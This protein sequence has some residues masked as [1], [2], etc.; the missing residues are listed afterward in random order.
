MADS[1]TREIRHHWEEIAEQELGETPE[2]RTKCLAELRHLLSEDTLLRCPEDD[3]F[4]LK[5]LR[6]R[7]YHVEPTAKA[8]RAYFRA[9]TD[10][11]ELFRGLRPDSFDFDLLVRKHRLLMVLQER[12]SL[13]RAIGWLKIGAWDTSICSMVDLIRAAI[14]LTESAMLDEESQVNGAILVVD[15]TGFHLGHFRHLVPL[16]RR[17]VHLVQ[18][19]FPV[20]I[21]G[22]YTINFPSIAEVFLALL[23][24]FLKSKLLSRIYIVR[25]DYKMLHNAISPELLP[26]EFGGTRLD[27]N[28]DSL[29]A[30]LRNSQHFFEKMEKWGY[31]T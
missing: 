27:L 21:K 19:C 16:F 10:Y 29:Q 17:I 7:K 13:G 9:W 25:N 15:Y 31:H 22:V 28:L 6:C 3:A 14:I 12:D 11:P 2:V 26:P 30:R 18:N 20:R 24:P 8:I 1:N 4:L 5:F 23:K